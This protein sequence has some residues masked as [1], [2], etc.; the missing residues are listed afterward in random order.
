MEDKA[1]EASGPDDGAARVPW[2]LVEA[3]AVIRKVET[4]ARP[5]GLF[6]SLTGGVLYKGHSNKDLDI[7]F[8]LLGGL[9]R[10]FPHGALT[11]A[12][13]SLGWKEEASAEKV[14]QARRDKGETVTNHVAVWLTED[15]HRI[16]VFCFGETAE[17]EGPN[18]F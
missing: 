6:T 11:E 13:K 3:V 15:N 7:G 5:L 16:D 14:A 18:V 10:D 4:V 2:D 12:L 9:T 17:V 1:N 8:A